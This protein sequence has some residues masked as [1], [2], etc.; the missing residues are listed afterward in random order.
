[1]SKPVFSDP[2]VFTA[3][4]RSRRSFLLSLTAQGVSAGVL[5]TVAFAVWGTGTTPGDPTLLRL[6]TALTLLLTGMP[7]LLHHFCAAAQRCRDCG[8]TGWAAAALAVPILNLAMLMALSLCQGQPGR[9]RYG[10][11]PLRPTETSA[12]LDALLD[13][14]IMRARDP[15]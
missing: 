2:F 6:V 4:R 8:L 14:E 5:A 10:E 12:R 1:M 15:A 13:Q 3:G 7:L 11:D 9:N